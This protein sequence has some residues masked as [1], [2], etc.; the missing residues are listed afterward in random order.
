MAITFTKSIS[1]TEF[2]N[3]FNHNVVEFSS[4]DVLD[5]VKCE[6]NI[7]S[8]D[9]EITP[10]DD[11]VFTFDFLEAV[12]TFAAENRFADDIIPDEDIEADTTLQYSYEVTYTITFSDDSTE[13]TAKTY[14][15]LR[16]VE[17]IANVSN[18]L[19]TEQQVLT[20]TDLTFFNGYPFDVAH[21]SDGNITATNTVT[22]ATTVF[23]SVQGTTDRI[24]FSDG[25]ALASPASAFEDRV[26][27]D[28][29]TYEENSCFTSF[30]GGLINIGYNNITLVDSTTITLDILLKD[31]C[32]GVYLKF[33]NK[34][35]GYSYWL[36]NSIYKDK[37]TVKTIDIYN[38][39]FDSIDNTY[40]TELVTKRQPTFTKDLVANSLT[41]SQM[42]QIED[43]LDSP[44]IEMYN[45]DK[46]DAQSVSSWQTVT[47]KSASQIIKN[48][49]HSLINF[50]LKIKVNKYSI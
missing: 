31:I 20:P 9:F 14:V 45:G 23:T 6:V 34:K 4:D 27:T 36:F 25:T 50:K 18:R 24:F 32:S 35:G 33:A 19:I 43:I 1:T 21:Y 44:R 39:D 5:S 37:M 26:T 2:L 15:F 17:Q 7:N 42:S 40:T 38:T 3:A 8:I 13:D 29:G 12:S 28:S 48:T 49:K 22:G 47:V 11:N 41:Q 30:A 16:S 46:G 10:D